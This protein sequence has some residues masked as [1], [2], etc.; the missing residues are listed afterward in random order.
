MYLLVRR[1]AP[2]NRT[3]NDSNRTGRNPVAAER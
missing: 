3:Q 1:L 2:A